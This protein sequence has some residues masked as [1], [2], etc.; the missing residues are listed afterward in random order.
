MSKKE[1][2]QGRP[3]AVVLRVLKLMIQSYKFSFFMVVVCII[4]GAFA[5]MQGIP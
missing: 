4:L 1:K 3:A 5:T 2:N